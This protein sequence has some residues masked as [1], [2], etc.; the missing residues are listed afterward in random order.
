[1]SDHLPVL[2]TCALLACA[3]IVRAEVV[4]PSATYQNPTP[5]SGE[6]FGR[7]V[8][9]NGTDAF[10]SD[11]KAQEGGLHGAVYQFDLTSAAL[12][13][14]FGSPEGANEVQFGDRGAI[15]SLGDNLLVGDWAAKRQIN[16]SGLISFGGLAYRFGISSGTY[17]ETYSPVGHGTLT[18]GDY[19]AGICGVGNR[20]VVG[21][22][23]FK[24]LEVFDINGGFIV[25]Y[26]YLFLGTHSNFGAPIKPLGG[27]VVV[28]SGGGTDPNRAVYVIDIATGAI[29]LTIPDPRPT[30]GPT[31]SLFGE[32]VATN[33]AGTR[34][35]VGA[36]RGNTQPNIGEGPGVAY[37]YDA[38]GNLLRAIDAPPGANGGFFGWDVD[39][40][41]DNLLISAATNNASTGV[42]ALFDGDT[43]TL[44][45]LYDGYF[46]GEQFGYSI[47][48]VDDTRFLVGSLA[49]EAYLL[50]GPVDSCAGITP[51]GDMN[52]SGTT[53]GEDIGPFVQA[54]LT[55]TSTP[56]EVCHADFGHNNIVD[57]SDI[58]PLVELLLTE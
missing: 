28:G 12:I 10:V 37:L 36:Y 22:P 49:G 47:A 54:V 26:S 58:Q 14:T 19:G 55:G 42:V 27:S 8:Y 34:I 39:F 32:S 33:A 3:T 45:R 51:D 13:H 1:M 52:A 40:L 46:Q 23:F 56:P 20:A 4:A 41:G 43:G 25:R 50:P 6:V 38:S 30:N 29:T 18:G 5:M 24:A 7:N 15:G 35:L 31:T 44:I 11:S 57:E 48:S 53:D 21:W 2:V 17:Q 9:S 16:T